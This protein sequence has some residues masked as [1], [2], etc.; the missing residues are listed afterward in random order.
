MNLLLGKIHFLYLQRAW[1]KHSH[2]H[3]HFKT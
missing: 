1:S 3:L 2:F